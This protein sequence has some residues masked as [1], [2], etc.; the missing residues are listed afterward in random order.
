MP[1]PCVLCERLLKPDLPFFIL[2]M[3]ENANEMQHPGASEAR[4]PPCT[5]RSNALLI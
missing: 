1:L 5:N 2:H 4:D 3:Q